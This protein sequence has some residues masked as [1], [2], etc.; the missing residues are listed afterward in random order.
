[1][2]IRRQD[3][4]VISLATI[5]GNRIASGS[6]SGMIFVHSIESSVLIMKWHIDDCIFGY[7]EG[8]RTEFRS[9]A[10]L[11][12]KQVQTLKPHDYTVNRS[13]VLAD[14]A[15]LTSLKR[16][17]SL[18]LMHFQMIVVLFADN[19]KVDRKDQSCVVMCSS[20]DGFL[21]AWC[22][23]KGGGFIVA[24]VPFKMS[25]R[26]EIT[27]FIMDRTNSFLLTA[28]G[29]GYVKLWDISQ[30]QHQVFQKL[31]VVPNLKEPKYSRPEFISQLFMWR[32]HHDAI[33]RYFAKN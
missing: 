8:I 7:G 27:E 23:I 4:D 22:M 10:E 19:P 11:S 18:N 13:K 20:N 28:D 32:A 17:I 26:E 25:E 12:P 31:W 1:L 2:I 29:K 33:T 24:K 6:I 16:F 9:E 5:P 21:R 30:L 3:Q 15:S 14:K